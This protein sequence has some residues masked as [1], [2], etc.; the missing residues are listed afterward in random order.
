[1][2]PGK[3]HVG[4]DVCPYCRTDDVEIHDH[5]PE[6]DHEGDMVCQDFRCCKCEREWTVEYRPVAYFIFNDREEFIDTPNLLTEVPHEEGG[7]STDDNE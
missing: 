3:K 5:R 6:Y 7:K 4:L 1:M 2:T